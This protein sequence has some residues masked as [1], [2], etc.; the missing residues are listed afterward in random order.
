MSIDLDALIDLELATPHYR[1]RS[2]LLNE[3]FLKNTISQRR[4]AANNTIDFLVPLNALLI[5]FD[6]ILLPDV[7]MYSFLSRWVIGPAC[8]VHHSQSSTGTVSNRMEW[9]IAA[10]I[11]RRHR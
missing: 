1:R 10:A 7:L 2:P 9:F 3:L 11:Y 8:M 5:V 6:Y 4:R